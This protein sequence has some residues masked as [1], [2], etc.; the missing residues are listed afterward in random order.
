MRSLRTA[1]KGSPCSPQKE[2]PERNVKDPAQPKIN[3]QTYMRVCVCVCVY[4]EQRKRTSKQKYVAADD[5]VTLVMPQ[6]L[7]SR[8]PSPSK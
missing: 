6:V 5:T 4:K 7:F 3:K 8:H 2:K 1:K